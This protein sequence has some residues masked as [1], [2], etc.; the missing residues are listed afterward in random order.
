MAFCVAGESY[1]ELLDALYDLR[2]E[3]QLITCRHEA[4]A[5]HMAEAYG[6]LTGKPGV[7]LVTRGPGACHASIGIHAA[8]Q[9]S[10]PMVVLVGQV[11]RDHGEREAFQEIDYRRMF[12]PLTKW[13]AQIDQAER[14]PEMMGRAFQTAVSGRPGPVVLALPEDM[15]RE[16][17][18]VDDV[19]TYMVVQSSP[20][21]A[22][23]AELQRLL[24]EAERPVVLV[25]GGGWTPAACADVVRFAGAYDLPVCCSFRRQDIFNNDHP[26]F[27]GDLST[28]T[29]PPLIKRI[30]SSDLLV[31]IGSRLD[32]IA[33]QRYTLLDLPTPKQTLVHVH[34]DA[35]V[36]GSVYRPTL[37]IQSGMAEFAAAAAALK[38]GGGSRWSAWRAEARKDYEAAAVPSPY[39]GDLDL[40]AC[41]LWLRDRL[42]ADA[43]VALDAGNFSGWPMRFLKWRQPRTQ[44]GPQA[45]AMGQGVPAAIAAKLVHPDR[46]VV[47][48]AGDGGF[49]MNGQ[50]LATAVKYGANIV[51]LVFNNGMFGTIRMHQER[52]HP[53][54]EHATALTNPDF[55]DLARAYGA[56]GETVV[57]TV[58]FAPAFER[59]L[60][61]GKP[62]IID[63]RM[64]PDVITTRTTLTAIRAAAE[65]RRA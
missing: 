61:S 58:D 18:A 15:Q 27:V 48:C 65:A 37:A 64:D 53:G 7:C 40:G 16:Q 30:K 11:D 14:I 31:V 22:A 43:I 32:E 13:V 59:A 39:T 3:I 17:A 41:M 12:G 60:A 36:L 42:P 8:H 56:H 5:A 57:K 44:L 24:G 63:L 50:E 19:G 21:A 55:A 20:S 62:A 6:K 1:L 2:N 51:M 46:I 54:R 10:T 35:A 49:M 34:Q 38:P 47:G 33:T 9:A 23:M 26:S 52:D 29:N 25:G 28:G 4:G 45:G